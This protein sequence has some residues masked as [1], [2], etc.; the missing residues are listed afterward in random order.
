MT[1]IGYYFDDM[2][3]LCHPPVSNLLSLTEGGDFVEEAEE[4]GQKHYI[5][6]TNPLV[7]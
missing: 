7:A 5:Y 4:I 1:N 6:C 3:L 2:L